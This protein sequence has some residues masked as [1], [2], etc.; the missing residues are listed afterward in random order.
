MRVTLEILL[1][2]Q[3]HFSIVS[4]SVDVTMTTNNHDFQQA[5]FLGLIGG[6]DEVIALHPDGVQRHHGEWRV[7][8]LD[9]PE[10]NLR[11]EK[12]SCNDDG[13]R[14][15]NT[16]MQDVSGCAVS[17]RLALCRMQRTSSPCNGT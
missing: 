15:A 6:S 7:S 4:W 12:C 3:L 10:S 1:R 5:W 9:D 8:P 11:V 14:L 17:Q 16:W 13:M 2:D